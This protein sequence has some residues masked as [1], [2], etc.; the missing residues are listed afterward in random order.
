[1]GDM[2]M[3]AHTMRLAGELLGLAS[4]EFSNHGCADFDLAALV[5]DVE[6]RRAIMLRVDQWNEQ[7]VDPRNY[8]PAGDYR[9]VPGWLLMRWL[10]VQLVAGQHVEWS[11]DKLTP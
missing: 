11:R 4:S 2:S 3:R 5:P 9:T 6:V 10:G 1:M 8:D 7:R